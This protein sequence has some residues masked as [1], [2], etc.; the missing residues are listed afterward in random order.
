MNLILYLRYS[1]EWLSYRI[2]SYYYEDHQSVLIDWCCARCSEG[3]YIIAH[4]EKI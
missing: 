2:T 3:C 4:I 1:F